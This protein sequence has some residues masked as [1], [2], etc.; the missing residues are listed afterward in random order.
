MA[1]TRTSLLN[2]WREALDRDPLERGVLDA[3]VTHVRYSPRPYVLSHKLWYLRVPLAD[4]DRLE[5]RFMRRNRF[6]LFS[7]YDRDYGD[8]RKEPAA[9]IADAFKSTGARLPGDAEIVLVTLP[10]VT[11]FG[12]NPVSFWL[13]HDVD[14]ALI[15][16]LAEVNNTFGERHCYLCRKADGTPI[17]P[18]DEIEAEKV[19]HVS[20]FLPVDGT[21]KFRFIETSD[22]LAVS[23][24]LYRDQRH[25]LSATIAGRL[26]ALTSRALLA[27]FL[28]RPFPAMQVVLLIHYH[29][30]RL[31]MRGLKPFAK[32]P[33]PDIFVTTG[34]VVTAPESR[35]ERP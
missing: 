35:T 14:G 11:G 7:L 30:A 12:F 4:L 19:F 3:R 24:D 29:A 25:V 1:L 16:V 22:R 34:D 26:A 27:R 10:R 13:C 20:P 9:W 33:P 6:G 5:R 8:S 15:A 23:I 32:P 2:S 28:R 31:Y 17:G 21:Y 18:G